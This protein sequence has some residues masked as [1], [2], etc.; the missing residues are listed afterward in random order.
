MKK[1][2]KKHHISLYYTEICVD[3][4]RCIYIHTCIFY[5]IVDPTICEII[6]KKNLFFFLYYLEL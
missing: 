6:C 5:N 3:R 4:H 2:E 1:I